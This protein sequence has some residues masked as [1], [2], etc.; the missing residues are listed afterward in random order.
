[1]S[2]LKMMLGVAVLGLL[3]QTGLAA[4]GAPTH[5]QLKIAVQQI[6]PVMG[7]RLGAHGPPIKVRIGEENI[8]LCCKAC[9]KKPINPTHWA[10]IHTNFRTSQK[11]CPVMKHELPATAKWTFVKGQ[12]VYVC[13]P[14]CTDKIAAAPDAYLKKIDELYTASLRSRQAHR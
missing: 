4:D 1:M 13:C 3:V 12:I 8:F 7:E 14:P 9:L 6:C 5:D 11:I 2:V 10:T